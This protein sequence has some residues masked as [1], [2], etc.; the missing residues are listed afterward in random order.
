M[1]GR[2]RPPKDAASRRGV[3]ISFRVSQSLREQLEVAR[4][5]GESER[6]L[7]AE[8]ELRLRRSFDGDADVQKHFS[9]SRL[10][11]LS[12]YIARDIV[13]IEESTG[14]EA[15]WLDDPFVYDEVRAYIDT[16]FDH[17]RRPRGRKRVPKQLAMEP[18]F[19]KS[20][21]LLTIYELRGAP[22][23]PDFFNALQGVRNTINSLAKHPSP[24]LINSVAAAM[25]LA[26]R[27]KSVDR[28][29]EGSLEETLVRE[30]QRL[31]G[32]FKK[33]AEKGKT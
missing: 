16:L 15:R 4:R 5:E 11:W 22:R 1:A 21:A 32:T 17:M 9:S 33:E 14:P 2:G 13:H 31:M 18:H 10:Y 30:W 29:L 25:P 24:N 26:G 23:D 3:Q 20:M 27:L 19:G 7:S 6:S 8:I 12:R 28:R